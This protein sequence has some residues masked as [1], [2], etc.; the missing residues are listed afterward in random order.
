MEVK[1]FFEKLFHSIRYNHK[2]Q[3]GIF[4]GFLILSSIIV[5]GGI[6]YSIL[7]LND[8]PIADSH[9]PVIEEKEEELMDRLKF[10]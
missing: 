3:L 5:W 9:L 2:T 6:L 4:V 1:Y 8:E 7:N 10:Y